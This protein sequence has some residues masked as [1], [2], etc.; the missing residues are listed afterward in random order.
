MNNTYNKTNLLKK[1]TALQYDAKESNAPKVTAQ[2]TGAI[3]NNI[4]KIAK[5]FDI[6]IKEDPDL[7]EIL[8]QIEVN[9]EI[10]AELYKAVVEIFSFIYGISSK[11]V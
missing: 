3:A 10:P 1:A 6:P 11:N 5:E 2:G 7:V 8:S 9:E 4:I